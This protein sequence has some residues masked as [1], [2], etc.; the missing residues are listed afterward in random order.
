MKSMFAKEKEENAKKFAELAKEKEENAKKFAELTKE[1]EENAKKFAELTK[2]IAEMKEGNAK[3]FAEHDERLAKLEVYISY[4][5][6]REFVNTLFLAKTEEAR[7]RCEKITGGE[8]AVVHLIDFLNY[9]VH[10]KNLLGGKI[11]LSQE[12]FIYPPE[13]WKRGKKARA[14]GAD[15]SPPDI[16]TTVKEIYELYYSNLDNF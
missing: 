13:L 15:S 2:E 6:F 16:F 7:A 4:A 10:E 3:K 9:V 5:A 8:D 12:A 1:K 14:A 11:C